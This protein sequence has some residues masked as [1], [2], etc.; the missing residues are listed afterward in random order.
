M[1]IDEAYAR[2]VMMFGRNRLDDVQ[3]ADGEKAYCLMLF[4]ELEPPASTMSDVDMEWG[5]M[6]ILLRNFQSRNRK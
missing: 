4:R 2:Y 6:V 3:W 1:T 5:A